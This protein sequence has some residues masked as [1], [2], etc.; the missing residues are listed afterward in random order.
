[1][2]GWRAILKSIDQCCCIRVFIE[3]NETLVSL[4]A[5]KST[6]DIIF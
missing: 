1:M 6:V 4:M 5:I 3:L 2:T